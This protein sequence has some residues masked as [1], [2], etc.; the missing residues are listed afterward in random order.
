MQLEN[1]VQGVLPNS[2]Y[3]FQATLSN[4]MRADCLIR[5][6]KPPGDICVDA[7]FPLESYRALRAASDAER[8][9]ALRASPPTCSSTS[10]TSPASTCCP[11]RQPRVP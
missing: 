4:G 7:K 8:A 2:A 6:P 1:L 10:T 11:A 9:A 5:L 3:Q